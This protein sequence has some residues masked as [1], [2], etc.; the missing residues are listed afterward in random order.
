MKRTVDEKLK[1]NRE[2]KTPFSYGYVWGVQAYRR[3]PKAN[4]KERK[5]ILEEIDNYKQLA[6]NGGTQSRQCGKGFMCAVRDCAEERKA[7]P[8]RR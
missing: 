4:A 7:K 8:K 6:K 2:Q 5:R 3:Y 1:Y